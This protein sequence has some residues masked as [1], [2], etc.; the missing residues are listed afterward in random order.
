MESSFAL[1]AI[2]IFSHTIYYRWGRKRRG[3]E[4][5]TTNPKQTNTI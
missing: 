1:I 2:K 4:K 5:P 3:E